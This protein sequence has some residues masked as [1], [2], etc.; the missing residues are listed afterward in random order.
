MRLTEIDPVLFDT[1]YYVEPDRGGEKPYAV[2][3]TALSDSGYAALGMFAMHGRE[4]AAVVRPGS[5][6]LILHTLFYAN[7]VRAEGEYAV[8]ASLAGA[9]ERQLAVTL[10]EALAAPFELAKLKNGQEERLRA[11]IESRAEKAVPA[12]GAEPARVAAPPIDIWK[13]S[14]RVWQ[15]QKSP[16]RARQDLPRC[17][18]A[19]VAKKIRKALAAITPMHA[20]RT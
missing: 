20:G 4:H 19:A 1:S 11:L 10:V 6:G 13:P 2:L 17:S 16:R 14:R 9:K 8:D 18:G 5:R 12:L 3:Y 7:E 15:L